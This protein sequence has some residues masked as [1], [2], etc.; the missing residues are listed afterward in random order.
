M[1]AK[2]STRRGRIPTPK[3]KTEQKMYKG[4]LHTKEEE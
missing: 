4:N 2:K 1:N 3:K